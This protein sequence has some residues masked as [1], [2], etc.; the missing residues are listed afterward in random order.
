MHLS[1]ALALLSA[2]C[3][4]AQD[5][6]AGVDLFDGESLSGWNVREGEES[7]WRVQ[8]GLLTGGSLERRVPHNTFLCSEASYQNFELTLEIRIVGTEGFI[9]SGIQ[10]RSRRVQGKHEMSGY[11]VDAGD[12]WWG[13]LYDES[14]RNRVLS[15]ST[16]LQEI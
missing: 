5:E 7:W 1:T 2:W 9:N 4:L 12:E 16:R 11:Q 6:G 15:E 13:K 14:R 10:I 8:D 3:P